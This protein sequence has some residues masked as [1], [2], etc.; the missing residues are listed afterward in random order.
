[1]LLCNRLPSHLKLTECKRRP[2]QNE[3]RAKKRQIGKHSYYLTFHKNKSTSLQRLNGALQLDANT[4]SQPW[5]TECGEDRAWRRHD[6]VTL[7]CKFGVAQPR[8]LLLINNNQKNN[9]AC[10]GYDLAMQQSQEDFQ[11]HRLTRCAIVHPRNLV[12]L[13]KQ[14]WH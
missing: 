3:L 2:E 8:D 4:S 13:A 5:H 10:L 14:T 12:K 6:S 1:M 7:C 11:R 9:T